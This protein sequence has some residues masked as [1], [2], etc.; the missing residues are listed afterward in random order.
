M[1]HSVFITARALEE[2]DQALDWLARQSETA[3]RRWHERL[4]EAV[5]SLEHQPE[6]CE[7]AP[8]GDW[9]GADIR[10][11]LFG[12]RSG[13]YRILF[14]IRKNKVYILRVRHSA[15]ALLEPGEL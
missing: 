11:L 1:A 13:V 6:R 9:F 3:A 4:M 10:Q 14:V 7:I 15:Q 5:R 2:I 8:E 12:R